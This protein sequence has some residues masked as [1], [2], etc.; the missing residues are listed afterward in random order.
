[1]CIIAFMSGVD[2]PKEKIAYV[3]VVLLWR[4]EVGW[5]ARRVETRC[6]VVARRR[7]RSTTPTVDVDVDKGQ[8]GTGQGKQGRE[9]TTER[10]SA[11]HSVAVDFVMTLMKPSCI[12][13]HS[14]S[15]R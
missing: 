9:E 3:F 15:I 7:G 10:G 13:V 1:M 6:T 2:T 14:I 11:V 12:R 4:G 8:A 5:Q